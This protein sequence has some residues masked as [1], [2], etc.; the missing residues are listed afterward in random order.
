VRAG[1]DG[2]SERA[3]V[4]DAFDEEVRDVVGTWI[5]YVCFEFQEDAWLRWVVA[6]GGRNIPPV[7]RCSASPSLR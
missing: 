4:L 2:F 6:G 7:C 5:G 1:E 3:V